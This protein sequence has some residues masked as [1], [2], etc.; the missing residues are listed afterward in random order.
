LGARVYFPD[1]DPE[2]TYPE[3][4]ISKAIE[5]REKQEIPGSETYINIYP[6][7]TQEI[8]YGALW[9]ELPFVGSRY[10]SREDKIQALIK[11]T[12]VALESSIRL[13]EIS[14]TYKKL[15]TTLYKQKSTWDAM[16]QG[17]V[18]ALD[19]HEHETA[20]H[21][22]RIAKLSWLVGREM[23]FKGQN[24]QD[25]KDGALLHDIGKMGIKDAILANKGPLSPDE[26]EKMREHVT[27]GSKIV[28][29]IPGMEG[30]AEI[31]A[32]YH[33]LWNGSGYPNG[34]EGQFIPKLAR[35]VTVA[36]VFDAMTCD[37]PYRAALP[38]DEVLH[39]IKTQAGILFDP[40][41]VSALINVLS[42]QEYS[43]ESLNVW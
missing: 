42:S 30:A 35:I 20:N 10:L 34:K 23:G 4:A 37:R 40:S 32:N 16:I 7:M 27:I 11:Q 29:D 38:R 33:E 26:I 25:L 2:M 18:Q 9:L 28:Q 36:D 22:F 12:A 1:D 6:M 24:L 39:Y 13:H 3:V 5:S 41:V 19:K 8:C 31:I 15:E 14:N 17:F 21:S 43:S